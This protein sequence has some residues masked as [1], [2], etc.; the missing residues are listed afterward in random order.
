MLIL[1]RNIVQ[2]YLLTNNQQSMNINEIINDL[3]I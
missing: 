1:I 2:N 3:Y